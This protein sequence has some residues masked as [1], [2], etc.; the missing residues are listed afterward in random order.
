VENESLRLAELFLS[1]E[2]LVVPTRFLE[3]P[4]TTF[5]SQTGSQKAIVALWK[6]WRDDDRYKKSWS[7]WQQFVR[8]ER[9][10]KRVL[11]VEWKQRK[12][13]PNTQENR[14]RLHE[15]NWQESRLHWRKA[16]F[17]RGFAKRYGLPPID[18][19]CGIVKFMEGVEKD[20]QRAIGAWDIGRWHKAVWRVDDE[21]DMHRA[22]EAYAH[23]HAGLLVVI[24]PHFST[25]KILAAVQKQV[26]EWRAKQRFSTILP[27][28]TYAGFLSSSEPRA[29]PL[30]TIRGYHHSFTA[31]VLNEGLWFG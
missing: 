20:V 10:F 18:P 9:K 22:T 28:R 2:E 7:R 29:P 21:D 11:D 16:R 1:P 25:P 5:R 30:D 14:Q 31:A 19:K 24:D 6:V 13:K 23:A 12:S 3:P 15:L 17:L 8:L 27:A 26:R 4:I